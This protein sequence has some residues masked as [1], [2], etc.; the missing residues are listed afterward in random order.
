MNEEII[1]MLKLDMM[2]EHQAI[3]Q[4]L[5]HAYA[6]GE[7]SLAYEVEAISRDEMRHLDWLADLIVEL[8]GEPTM[9]RAPVDFSPGTVSEQMLKNV[10]TEQVAIDQY[11]DHLEAIADPHVRLV[12]TRIVHDELVHKGL[13]AGYSAEAQS[14]ALQNVS[15]VEPSTE[16]GKRAEE[17]LNQGVR[18]EYTVILQY[19]Y[20]AFLARDKELAEE[21]QDIAVNEMQH[22]G[23]LAEALVGEH[24][25][26]DLSHSDLVL[27]DEP[28]KMLEA[29]IAAEREV[30][31]NYTEQLTELTDPDLQGLVERIRDHEIYHDAQFGELL[32]EA[33]QEASAE[34]PAACSQQATSPEPPSTPEIPSVGS[35]IG[36]K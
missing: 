5:A 35:L 20:H 12:L 25:A 11:R 3:I 31:H 8:G 23:W 22:M 33:E 4:Y 15:V 29:D 27:A 28:Q 16:T 10:A 24:G 17:I 6:M 36:Q 13:F 7:V 9:E 26:P 21:M 19:L 30:T 32:A 34:K 1:A 2:G 18:H 14:E